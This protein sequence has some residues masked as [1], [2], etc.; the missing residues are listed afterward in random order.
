[1]KSDLRSEAFRSRVGA[2]SAFSDLSDGRN[3]RIATA[4]TMNDKTPE[5]KCR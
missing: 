4:S 5:P 3:R 1:V 2:M